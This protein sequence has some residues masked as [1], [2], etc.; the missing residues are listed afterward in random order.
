[1]NKEGMN[2]DITDNGDEWKKEAV[3]I[4]YRPYINRI[5]LRQ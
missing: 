2:T 4:L 5:W 1:M 3:Y